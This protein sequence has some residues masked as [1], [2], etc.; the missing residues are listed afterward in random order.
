MYKSGQI[1][2][3]IAYQVL[4]V[5]VMYHFGVIWVDEVTDEVFVLHNSGEGFTLKESFDEFILDREFVELQESKLEYLTNEELLKRFE[6]CEGKFDA[7]DYNCEHFVDCMLGHKKKSE[8][9][10]IYV[11]AAIALF[12]IFK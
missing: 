10:R 11:L 4:D 9:L 12:I 8:Q 2:K 5:P 3:T 1:V 6:K 7:L